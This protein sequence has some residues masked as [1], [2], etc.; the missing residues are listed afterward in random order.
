MV[1]LA[2]KPMPKDWNDYRGITLLCVASKVMTRIILNRLAPPLLDC[3]Y[4]F[5]RSRSTKQ[6]VCA[7]KS[8]LSSSARTGRPITTVFVDC[9]KAYDSIEHDPLWDILTAYGIGPRSS[10]IIRQ[11]YDSEYMIRLN[12]TKSKAFKA[13]RGVKQGCLLSPML[14]NICLDSAL[15]RCLPELRGLRAAS[16]RGLPMVLRLQADRMRSA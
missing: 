1:A 13:T 14:F 11:L 6:A 7:L 12:G 9:E 15:R 8:I 16:R 4:G 2:K 3:Q 10:V 5:R